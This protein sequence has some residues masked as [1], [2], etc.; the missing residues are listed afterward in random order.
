MGIK[1]RK[2]LALVPSPLRLPPRKKPKMRKKS[3][4]LLSGS[5]KSPFLAEIRAYFENGKI[6]FQIF[7]SDNLGQNIWDKR[8]FFLFVPIYFVQDCLREKFERENGNFSFRANFD[9]FKPITIQ[10]WRKIGQKSKKNHQKVTKCPPPLS[11]GK[12][13]WKNY[14]LGPTR[15][16]S[17]SVSYH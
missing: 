7:N 13:S 8:F 5:S 16:T 11:K 17:G 4:F 9:S 1:A 14:P 15:G 6:P 3:F 10:N 12:L 2:K